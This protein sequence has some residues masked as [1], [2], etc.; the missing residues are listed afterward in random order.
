MTLRETL[1]PW[2]DALKSGKYLQCYGSYDG[3]L[4]DSH[5]AI[6]VANRVGVDAENILSPNKADIIIALNDTGKLSFHEIAERIE[7]WILQDELEAKQALETVEKTQEEL[8][9]VTV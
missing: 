9:L 4:P 3:R 7:E 6:G 5:C 2:I 1:Q 8:A